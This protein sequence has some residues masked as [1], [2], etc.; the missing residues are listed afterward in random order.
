[1]ETW[2]SSGPSGGATAVQQDP[3]KEK[4]KPR[5]SHAG[6]EMKLSVRRTLEKAA[7]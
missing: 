5:F 7:A 4:T 2:N 1:V 3:S 6:V